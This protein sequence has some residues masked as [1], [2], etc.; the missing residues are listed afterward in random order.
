MPEKTDVVFETPWFSVE[1]RQLPLIQGASETTQYYKINYPRGVVILPVTPE[2]DFVLIR[3]YRPVLDKITIEI[4]AGAIDG[5]ETPERAALRELA[6]ETGYHCDTL[7]SVGSGV[8]RVDRED[9]LNCFYVAQN[10][11]PI[12]GATCE[13]GIELLLVSPREFKTLFQNNQF[14]H[15]AAA[16]IFMMAEFNHGINLF[17]NDHRN[18][19]NDI[20]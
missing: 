6:E 2:G 16:P 7:V 13:D 18:N 5:D 14:D 4:P 11:T 10:A 9:A 3:Q 20:A 8:L 17:D 19:R 15:I 12:P 1:E